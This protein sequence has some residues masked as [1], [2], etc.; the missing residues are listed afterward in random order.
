V[1]QA[2]FD[3]GVK[4]W[5]KVAIPDAISTC[6]AHI[7]KCIIYLLINY[8]PTTCGLK[9][10]LIAAVL[11]T[12]EAKAS[13]GSNPSPS[14]KLPPQMRP[15]AAS[16]SPSSRAR[17]AAGRRL[18]QW[19]KTSVEKGLLA[20]RGARDKLSDGAAPRFGSIGRQNRRS[21]AGLRERPRIPS[22][23]ERSGDAVFSPQRLSF[24]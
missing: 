4:M 8:D 9:L 3:R 12:A 19:R 23:P 13:G 16:A 20:R 17:L 5:P 21:I 18:F 2:R 10:C 6:F 22:A 15:L 11:K 7:S 1:H 14:A 24:P